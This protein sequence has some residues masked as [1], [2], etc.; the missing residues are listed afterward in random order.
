VTIP[1]VIE[2]LTVGT[3]IL[4][5]GLWLGSLDNR[6]QAGEV[7]L[8][9]VSVDVKAAPTQIAVLQTQMTSVQDTQ[10]KQDEKLDRILEE[11]RRR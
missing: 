4:A 11:V 2:Y 10:K 9:E 3:A 7:Q 1:R 5:G 6:V 8:K